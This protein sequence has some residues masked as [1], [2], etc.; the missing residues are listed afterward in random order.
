MQVMCG[1]QARSL[2]KAGEARATGS[3]VV[4]VPSLPFSLSIR[5]IRD[6]FKKTDAGC[7]PLPG[8]GAPTGTSQPGIHF[9]WSHF[10]PEVQPET[11]GTLRVP[12]LGAQHEGASL[13]SEA[14]PTRQHSHMPP[15]ELQCPPTLRGGGALEAGRQRLPHKRR[16]PPQRLPPAQ[17]RALPNTASSNTASSNTASSATASSN[18]HCPPGHFG[19]GLPARHTRPPLAPAPSPTVP[20]PHND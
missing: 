4:L 19:G 1:E 15:T 2:R 5:W 10:H 16:T 20:K 3:M 18:Q 14:V 11:Q 17:P 8:L 9:E 12:G 13:T 6:S 7:P